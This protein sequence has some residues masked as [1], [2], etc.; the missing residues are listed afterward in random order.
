MYLFQRNGTALHCATQQGHEVLALWL[1]TETPVDVHAE[2]D[3]SQ[4][5]QS[6]ICHSY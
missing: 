3:V 4:N 2:D 1:I 6:F 5:D